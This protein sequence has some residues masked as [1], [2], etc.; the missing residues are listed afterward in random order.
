MPVFYVLI[1]TLDKILGWETG[2]FLYLIFNKS[3]PCYVFFFFPLV[4]NL[5]CVC[6]LFY[7]YNF[8]LYRR[9]LIH[10]SRKDNFLS[11]FYF[12]SLFM[13]ISLFCATFYHYCYY[14]CMYL[15]RPHRRFESRRNIHSL[16][17]SFDVLLI[18]CCN[19][20]KKVRSGFLF[21]YNSFGLNAWLCFCVVL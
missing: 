13:I 14:I 15:C 11:Y 21:I 9:V 6:I 1:L 20:C 4:I 3:W 7:I 19:D 16:V 5:L 8:F 2:W 17:V 18:L 10:E 12:V